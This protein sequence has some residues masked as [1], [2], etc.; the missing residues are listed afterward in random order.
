[1]ILDEQSVSA[2]LRG[3]EGDVPIDLV[4]RTRSGG[5]R[6]VVRRRAYAVLGVAA[7]VAVAVPTVHVVR[8][9]GG[10]A[11]E[12]TRQQRVYPG[13]FAT[14]PDAGPQL[15][16]SGYSEKVAPERYPDVLYLPSGQAVRVL[17]VSH[18]SRVCPRP[19]QALTAVHLQDDGATFDRGLVVKGPNAPSAIQ[20]GAVGVP[21]ATFA[22]STGHSAIHGQPGVEL[23]VLKG[24]TAI[25]TA[26]WTEPNGGQWQA[27][28]RDMSQS[29]A[30]Q[31]LNRL[32]IDGKRG[33]A[34]LPHAAGDGW[35][36]EPAVPD[37]FLAGF[38]ALGAE[39]T[40]K[41]GH[42]V[43]MSVAQRCESPISETVAY[44][45]TFEMLAIRGGPA[46]LTTGRFPSLT[47]QVTPNVQV[48]M[49][50]TFGSPQELVDQAERL[51]LT[52]PDDP[53]ISKD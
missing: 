51:S 1:M 37:R 22:G 15:C 31:L 24:E 34:T 29:E 6:R 32:D 45:G 48:L 28:V 4:S 46:I 8:A 43:S 2:A 40:D 27:V 11:I 26:Y 19:H 33:T 52:T 16:A 36:I 53:R 25:T 30:V 12:P 23:T 5:R 41:L 17:A 20:M 21:G 18:E 44:A 50:M 39:W 47:W 3:I 10:R 42:R 7:A 14:P 35:T 38:G 13:L 49:T 9:S